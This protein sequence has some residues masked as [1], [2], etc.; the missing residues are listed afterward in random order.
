MD[1]PK[2][3]SLA[4]V[5]NYEPEKYLSD[6]DMAIIKTFTPKHLTVIRKMMLP[7]VV[8]AELPM[9]E[10]GQDCYLTGIDWMSM[11]AEHAKAIMQGRTEAIKFILGGLIKLRILAT[12]S[13][14]SPLQKEERMRK[15]SSR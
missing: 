10:M 7:T 6:E 8:D 13:V 9:E 4:D 5:L 11:P 14:E 15:S 2:P 3:A 1:K 12:G